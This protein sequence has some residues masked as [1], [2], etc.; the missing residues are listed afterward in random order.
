MKEP[1]FDANGYPTDE[2]LEAIKAWPFGEWTALWKF[3]RIAWHYKDA[4]REDDGNIKVST[5]GWSGNESIINAMQ[6][7]RG[8]WVTNWISSHRGG[9]YVFEDPETD[10]EG[11]G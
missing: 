9:G 5:G 11:R 4:I 7:N 2:T 8:F 6:I 1:T 3:I 10:T